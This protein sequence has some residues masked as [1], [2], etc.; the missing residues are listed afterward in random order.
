MTFVLGWLRKHCMDVF[1]YVADILKDVDLFD[2]DHRA[3]MTNEGSIYNDYDRCPLAL[4]H[5]NSDNLFCY[6][7][8]SNID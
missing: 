2:S 7:Q 4:L 3:N 6:S 8:T 1:H 5:S